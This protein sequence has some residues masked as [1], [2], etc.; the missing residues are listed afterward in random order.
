MGVVGS[1]KGNGL[2]LVEVE[3]GGQ[4][5]SDGKEYGAGLGGGVVVGAPR[6]WICQFEIEVVGVWFT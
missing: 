2:A 4:S 1:G 6:C 5:K 3:E